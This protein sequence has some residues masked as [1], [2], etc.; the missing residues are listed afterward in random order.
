M[1]KAKWII[2]IFIFLL[3]FILGS[4]LYQNYLGA[5]SNQFFYFDVSVVDDRSNL[6]DLLIRSAAEHEMG[7]FSVDRTTYNA[8]QAAITIYSTDAARTVLDEQ[9]VFEGEKRSLFS[10]ATDIHFQDFSGIIN[11]QSIVIFWLFLPW[12]WRYSSG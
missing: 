11:D 9:C 7:V 3:C 2:S 10:G 5:F 4:E 12:W 6:H 8:R 1:K